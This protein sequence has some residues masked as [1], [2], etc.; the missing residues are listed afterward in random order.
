MIISPKLLKGTK[1]AKTREYPNQPMENGLYRIESVKS[2]RHYLSID[3]SRH[4]GFR[5]KL[6]NKGWIEA[7][8]RRVFDAHETWTKG[9]MTC[10]FPGCWSRT[11]EDFNT[12][13]FSVTY[14]ASYQ[15]YTK[16]AW[17]AQWEDRRKKGYVV[18]DTYKIT[19]K[20]KVPFSK[21]TGKKYDILQRT[22][23][24]LRDIQ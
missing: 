5:A 10:T 2:S 15:D 22:R 8:T 18:L 1:M 4:Y 23:D 19:G 9:D 24:R 17:D 3:E 12:L 13:Y 6:K 7:D 14:V 11:Q 16:E 21:L 20:P